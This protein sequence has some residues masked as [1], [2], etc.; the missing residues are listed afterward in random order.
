MPSIGIPQLYGIWFTVLWQLVPDA[1]DTRI[2][3]CVFLITGIFQ[4]GSV[5]LSLIARKIPVRAKKRSLVK[6]LERWLDNAAIRPRQWY[7]PIAQQL[8]AAASAAGEIHL[9][10]DCSK[11]SF[12]HQLLMVAIAYKHRSLPLV[13][14]WVRH[15]RGHSTANKQLALLAYARNLIPEGVKVSLV[16]DTEFGHTAVIDQLNEWHWGY[17]LRQQGRYLV[18][19][20]DSDQWVRLDSLIQKM[21]EVLWFGDVSLTKLHACATH[22]T[23]YWAKGEKEPWLLATNLTNPQ[24]VLR[25]Y[26]R[27]MWIEEMFGD[28]KGHGFDLEASRLR[29]FLRLSRLTLVVALLYVWLVAFGSH[30]VYNGKRSQVDRNDRRDLSIFRIGWDFIEQLLAW[31]DPLEVILKPIFGPLP[32]FDDEP[33]FSVG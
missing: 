33:L 12:N 2:A 19:R 8:I 27:R 30:V 3:N 11:V 7:K 31:G 5:H 22:L 10:I 20:K 25:L 16:G 21:S 14:T 4:A 18:Q 29:H 23:L 32:D 1:P 26:R 13:W 24:A 17:A 28:L 9:L 6:R 15:K